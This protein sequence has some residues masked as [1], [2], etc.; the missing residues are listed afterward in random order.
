MMST[1]LLVNIGRTRI[2][3]HISSLSLFHFCCQCH[4]LRYHL[5][6]WMTESWWIFSGICSMFYSYNS[7]FSSGWLN[8]NVMLFRS[9]MWE[10][11]SCSK[12]MH[13]EIIK[14]DYREKFQIPNICISSKVFHRK[15]GWS[16]NKK[17]SYLWAIKRIYSKIIV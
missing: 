16:V 10:V 9:M 5:D 14:N 11:C 8:V 3:F 12:K 2:L 7:T 15:N 6:L 1:I 13:L 4:S 17:S